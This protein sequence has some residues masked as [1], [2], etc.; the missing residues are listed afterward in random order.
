[1]GVS[2]LAILD[3][4]A[5]GFDPERPVI[6]LDKFSQIA[7]EMQQTALDQ[8]QAIA[9]G[10]QPAGMGMMD[11]NQQDGR[12][13]ATMASPERP[14]F[15][16]ALHRLDRQTEARALAI[17]QAAKRDLSDVLD[18]YPADSPTLLSALTSAILMAARQLPSS[19]TSRAI[20]E[21]ARRLVAAQTGR[22]APEV[23]QLQLSY[24]AW[25]LAAT[26]IFT[27]EALRMQ[28]A[29]ADDAA[30][31][32]RLLTGKDGRSSA[33]ELARNSLSSAIVLLI[34]SHGNGL[35]IRLARA[36]GDRD[37]IEYQ[38]QAIAALDSRTTRICRAVNR[39]IQPLD[40]PFNTIV[41]PQMNPPFHHYCR[42]AVVLYHPSFED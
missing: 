34:W 11:V 6:P 9:N 16:Q 37:G 13:S 38:K 12:L 17:W 39:Q 33:W 1:M 18:R 25:R 29:G 21:A 23:D 14:F 2:E 20:Y 7:L 35:V 28:A 19:E 24:E 10:E 15:P 40:R 31:R 4:E 26:G 32:A 41:G 8:Q 36:A 30:M 22:D 27:S 5:L 42:T 3:D